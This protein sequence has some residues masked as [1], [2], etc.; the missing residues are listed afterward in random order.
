MTTNF[1]PGGLLADAL[2]RS[3]WVLLLRGIA[4]ALFGVMTLARPG[5]SLASLAFVFGIYALADGVLGV[6]TAFS[7]RQE[8]AHWWMLLLE[9]LLGV[10]VGVIALANPAVPALALLY[11]IAF[12]AIGVGVLEIVMA[13]RLRR[14]IDN[15]WRLVLAGLV[16]VI[17]G[18]WLVARPGAGA[19]AA[20]WVIGIFSLLF[21]ILLIVLAFKVRGAARSIQARFA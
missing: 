8:Q 16:S 10:V 12:R 11:Y 17:F 6:W 20:L 18:L 15:E 4:A 9:G 7:R 21:G 14:E 1:K 3:W 13:I 19:L 2:S 5:I